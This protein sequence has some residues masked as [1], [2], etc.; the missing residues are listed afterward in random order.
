[1]L[2]GQGI[3]DIPAEP[4]VH[5]PY[6]AKK[7]N[8]PSMLLWFTSTCACDACIRHSRPPRLHPLPR[9]APLRR[10]LPGRCLGAWGYWLRGGGAVVAGRCRLVGRCRAP[11][12]RLEEGDTRALAGRRHSRAGDCLAGWRHKGAGD[13]LA[14]GGERG[15]GGSLAGRRG[16]GA[17]GR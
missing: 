17:R 6:I 8:C 3:Q 2:T 14:S 1:M 11:A 12:L 9:V 4:R 15:E 16:G 13:R 5:A 10:L 7:V